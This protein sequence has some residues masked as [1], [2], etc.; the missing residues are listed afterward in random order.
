MLDI[1]TWDTRHSAI[2]RAIALI[3]FA[4][5]GEILGRCLIDARETVD[6]QLEYGRTVDP[7]TVA[8]WQKQAPLGG[9][10]QHHFSKDLLVAR[11]IEQI[12]EEIDAF[13]KRAPLGNAE[14]IWS[15][16]HFDMPII[17]DLFRT[18]EYDRDPIDGAVVIGEPPWPYWAE[19]DVRTL[20]VLT[21][22]VPAD[23]PHDPISDAEAQIQQVANALRLRTTA[24]RSASQHDQAA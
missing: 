6:E 4:E 21:A 11:N 8:W 20:D 24:K 10:I 14:K 7:S 1:E 12:L 23:H 16:G 9:H 2:V 17:R 19:A 5:T 13:V 18:Q 22:K 3:A 15:R